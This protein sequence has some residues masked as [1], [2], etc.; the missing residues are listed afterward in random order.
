V[1]VT[2]DDAYSLTDNRKL[3]VLELEDALN[4]MA[5]IDERQAHI[6]CLRLFGELDDDQI[7]DLLDVSKRTVERDWKM[8]KA[9]LRRELSSNDGN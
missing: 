2:L 9:W 8:A 4:R 7:A 1:K 3:E 5:A 6:A